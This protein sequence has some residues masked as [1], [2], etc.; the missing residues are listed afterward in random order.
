MGR[1][2][3]ITEEIRLLA[4]KLHEEHPKWTNKEI[5]NVIWA[6]VHE[7]DK[8]LPEHKRMPKNWPSEHAINRILPEIKREVERRKTEPD[9]HDKPWTIQSIAKYPIPPESLP[10]VLETW[11]CVQDFRSELKSE[12]KVDA[13]WI[14]QSY[15]PSPLTIRQAQWVARLHAA[16]KDTKALLGYSM[17][18]ADFERQAEVAGLDYFGSQWTT[19]EVYSEMI[20]R[21]FTHEEMEKI[22]GLSGHYVTRVG[23]AAKTLNEPKS[24]PKRRKRGAK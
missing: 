1:G 7:R 18:M 12:L 17:I 10:S 11:F 20:G 15:G 5:R 24:K 6:T 21:T 13:E 9:P 19:L 16:I 4:A 3:L 23:L 8:A 22:T 14:I 2:P